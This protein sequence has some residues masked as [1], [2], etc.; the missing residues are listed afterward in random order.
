MPR[1]DP[2]VNGHCSQEGCD[3][4]NF[5]SAIGQGFETHPNVSFSMNL[6]VSPEGNIWQLRRTCLANMFVGAEYWQGAREHTVRWRLQRSARGTLIFLQIGVV[7]LVSRVIEC[8]QTVVWGVNGLSS[9]IEAHVPFVY[10]KAC[11][12][13]RSWNTHHH[14]YFACMCFFFERGTWASSAPSRRG[15]HVFFDGDVARTRHQSRNAL[16]RER[17]FRNRH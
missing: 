16:M 4:F 13:K 5:V 9:S 3:S 11:S 1:G 12:S 2:Q 7:N 8:A 14:A 15:Q 10:Q 6:V 17:R